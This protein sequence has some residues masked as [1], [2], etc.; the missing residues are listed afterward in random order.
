MRTKPKVGVKIRLIR[1]FRELWLVFSTS[2]LQGFPLK[3]VQ[4]R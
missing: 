3:M 4:R 2:G 1:R